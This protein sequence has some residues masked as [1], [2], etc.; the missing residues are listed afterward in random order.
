MKDRTVALLASAFFL[1]NPGTIS[2]ARLV[3]ADLFVVLWGCAGLYAA[4]KFYDEGR[5]LWG[6]LCGIA[7]GLAFLSKLWLVLPYGLACFVLFFAKFLTKKS[8]RFLAIPVLAFVVFLVV[9][10]LHLLLVTILTPQDL[11]HWLTMYFGITLGNR[12]AGGGFDPAMWYRPWWFYFAG[13]FKIIFFAF[14]MILLGIPALKKRRDAIVTAIVVALILP[15][16]VFSLIRVK[17]TIYVFPAFPGLALLVALGLDYFFRSA[18]RIEIGTSAIV[19]IFVAAWFYR[20]GVFLSRELILIQAL[21]LLYLLAGLAGSHYTVLTRRAVAAVLLLAMLFVGVVAVRR[22]LGDRTYYREIAEYFKKSLLTSP[23]GKVSFISPN[24]G[25]I[26]FYTFRAGQYWQTYY[27]HEDDAAFE[28]NLIDRRQA[29]YVVD[30]SGKLYGGQ[31]SSR[32]WQALQG[33]ARDIT[34]DLEAS[35]GHPIALRI[36]VPLGS[37]QSR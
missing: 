19:S 35:I 20:Q 16:F 2:Y 1:L 33:H 30:P 6:I 10:S 12:V 3:T 32:E 21:Y 22:T 25:A 9:S 28:R 8:S 26:S 24:Y 5:T 36:F 11:N 27:F 15:I 17:E 34:P 23:P 14:P 31:P 13:L 4:C 37:T 7:L 18:S 29:F